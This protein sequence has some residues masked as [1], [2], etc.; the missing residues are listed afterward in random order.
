MFLQ[1]PPVHDPLQA[2]SSRVD[3]T[4]NSINFIVH[5]LHFRLLY[6]AQFSVEL[7]SLDVILASSRAFEPFLSCVVGYR[8]GL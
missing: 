7:V 3:V 2:Q 8:M 6:L 5:L 4:Y 1:F